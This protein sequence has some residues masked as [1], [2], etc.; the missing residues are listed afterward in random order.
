MLPVLPATCTVL[1]HRPEC[2]CKV[3]V[4]LNSL[5]NTHTHTDTI[6]SI[7]TDKRVLIKQ[8]SKNRLFWQKFWQ[9]CGQTMNAVLRPSPT[10]HH[11]TRS[12]S[13]PQPVTILAFS[14]Y[15]PWIFSNFPTTFIQSF[16]LG[17]SIGFLPQPEAFISAITS[18]CSRQTAN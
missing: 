1:K 8:A 2:D 12:S 9:L 18:C 11:C 10:A 15:L 7:Q 6:L 16:Q 4:Q 5:W 3:H 17:K 13:T 14:S